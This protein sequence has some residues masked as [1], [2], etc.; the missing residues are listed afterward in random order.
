VLAQLLREAVVPHSGGG[1]RSGW[2]G[3]WAA[4]LVGGSPAQDRVVITR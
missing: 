2:M 1:S 3:F 4:E